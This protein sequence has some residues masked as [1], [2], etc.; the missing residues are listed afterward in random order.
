MAQR[1]ARRQAEQ[2]AKQALRYELHLVE[3]NQASAAEL[4]EVCSIQQDA[5]LKALFRTR[6]WRAV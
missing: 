5:N 1:E 3:I 2:E 4:A 6:Q